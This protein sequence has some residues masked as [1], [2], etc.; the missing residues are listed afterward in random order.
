MTPAPGDA[1][2]ARRMGT[3]DRPSVS[4]TTTTSAPSNGWRASIS[5]STDQGRAASSARGHDVTC[6]HD[7]SPE[8]REV[9]RTITTVINASLRPRCRAYLRGIDDLADEVLDRQPVDIRHLMENRGMSQ[10]ELARR[11]SVD[12]SAVNNVLTGGRK[13]P[14]AWAAVLAREF[15]LPADWF[16]ER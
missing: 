5:S 2:Q 8:M 1:Y 4:E 12:R 10:A 14:S 9:E 16:L 7:V 13:V 6:S 15:E 3:T 11:L